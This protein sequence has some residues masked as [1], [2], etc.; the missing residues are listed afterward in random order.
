MGWAVVAVAG[1]RGV[2]QLRDALRPR[3]VWMSGVSD[4]WLFLA[5]QTGAGETGCGCGTPPRCLPPPML[6]SCVPLLVPVPGP[7][8]ESE[9]QQVL[10]RSKG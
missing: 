1:M 10:H 5:A 7:A 3:L 8:S 4:E 9:R 2:R 6:P